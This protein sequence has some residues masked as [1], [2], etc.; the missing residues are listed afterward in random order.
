[1]SKD[2][3]A[4]EHLLLLDGTRMVIEESHGLWVKFEAKRVKVTAERPHGIKYS[5]TL[6]DG[7]NERIL[8]FDNAHAVD[9]DNIFDHWHRDKTDKGRPYKYTNPGKLVEDFW[10]EVDKILNELESK[11]D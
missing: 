8:G 6:H 9:E 5:F 7:K 3:Q 10:K 4:L 11:H 2:D 1:M